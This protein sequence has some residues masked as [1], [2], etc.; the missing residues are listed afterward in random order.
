[1][2]AITSPGAKDSARQIGLYRQVQGVT[3]FVPLQR[4]EAHDSYRY[5]GI[6]LQ[7]DGRWQAMESVVLT[8]VRT[9]ASK[10]RQVR[11]PVDQAVMVLRSVVGG[12]LNY[13]L[14]A[15]PL[16]DACMRKVDKM[17]AAAIFSCA[18]LARGRRTT[19]AFLPQSAGG[20]GATS[21]VVLRKAVVLEKVLSWL[22]ATEYRHAD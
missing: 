17:V 9:W 6:M 1:L 14:T 8:K 15:A 21:A 11:L 2:V 18:G 19:W 10:V 22:N 7:P 20:F 12:L 4:V 3:V 5:L 16:S 13:V